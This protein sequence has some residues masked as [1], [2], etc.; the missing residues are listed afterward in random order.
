MDPVFITMHRNS[1]TDSI[2]AAHSNAI[3]K[4]RLVSGSSR[5]LALVN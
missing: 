5:P 1:D 2:V 3:L 4:T